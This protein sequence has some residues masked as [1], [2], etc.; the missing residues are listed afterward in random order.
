MGGDMLNV[1][2]LFA[3]MPEAWHRW[4]CHIDVAF[5]LTPYNCV[6][7]GLYAEYAASNCLEIAEK[8]LD[9]SQR[10]VFVHYRVRAKG[11]VPAFSCYAV[12]PLR[13]KPKIGPF[14]ARSA[15]GGAAPWEFFA[16]D[17]LFEIWNRPNGNA[18]STSTLM[19][20]VGGRN[21]QEADRHWMQCARPFRALDREFR[22]REKSSIS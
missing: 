5:S 18:G 11:F 1:S 20:R 3:E 2:G 17:T 4:P 19:L 13:K 21:E 7:R 16:D 22:A 8:V 15:M 12:A 14:Q 9:T 6:Y 10:H